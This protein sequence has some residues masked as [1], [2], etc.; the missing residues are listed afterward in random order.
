MITHRNLPSWNNKFS[1][2]RH[3]YKICDPL[4]FLGWALSLKNKQYN[5]IKKKI[6]VENNIIQKWKISCFFLYFIVFLFFSFFVM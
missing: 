3:K 2:L 6:E 1:E 5:Q 4:C